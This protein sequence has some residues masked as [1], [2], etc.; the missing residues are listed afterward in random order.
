[1]DAEVVQWLRE[2]DKATPAQFMQKLRELYS[3]KDMLERFPHGF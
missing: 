2:Q 3:R 1:M